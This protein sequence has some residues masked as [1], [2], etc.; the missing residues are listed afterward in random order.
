MQ[1]NTYHLRYSFIHFECISYSKSE[2][3]IGSKSMNLLYIY[4]Y[5]YIYIYIY[6]I[7]KEMSNLLWLLFPADLF[8]ILQMLQSDCF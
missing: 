5:M 6:Y 2:T 4:I 7:Y 1:C 3:I 8:N